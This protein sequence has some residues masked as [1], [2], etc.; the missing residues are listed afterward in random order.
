VHTGLH[1]RS[2]CTGTVVGNTLKW[3][4]KVTKPVSLTL[5]YDVQIESDR[6]AGKV[7]MGFFGTAKLTGERLQASGS[8]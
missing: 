5:K 6:L 7:K 4:R 2:G 3:D 1:R 8:V